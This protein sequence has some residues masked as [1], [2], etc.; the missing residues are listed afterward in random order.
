ML[1][2]NGRWVESWMKLVIWTDADDP[3]EGYVEENGDVIFYD[4]P[5][6]FNFEMGDQIQYRTELGVNCY[7]VVD[8]DLVSPFDGWGKQVTVRAMEA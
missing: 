1:T 7:I 8:V 6:L 2:D 4:N 5:A 3:V